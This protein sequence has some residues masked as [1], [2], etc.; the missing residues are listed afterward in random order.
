M[1]GN[2]RVGV[3][4]FSADTAR[5]ILGEC[6]L[7]SSKLRVVAGKADFTTDAL[8]ESILLLRAPIS[9]EG[10]RPVVQR[11]CV[12]AAKADRDQIVV[13]ELESLVRGDPVG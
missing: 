12:V 7:V 11:K 5:P 2:R 8:F 6:G 9:A 10:L 4:S 13:L 3:I 1:S